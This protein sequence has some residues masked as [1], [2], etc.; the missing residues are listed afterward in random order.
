MTALMLLGA[1]FFSCKTFANKITDYF[2]L[3]NEAELLICDGHVKSAI[4]H[5]DRAFELQVSPFGKDVYNAWLCAYMLDDT[6]RFSQ[7][8]IILIRRGAFLHESTH[9]N[10]LNQVSGGPKVEKFSAI[11]R[12]LKAETPSE[13]DTVY[14][15]QL[16]NIF[17]RDQAVRHYFIDK[18]KNQYNIGGRDSLNVFD[19]LNTMHLKHLMQEKG[20]PTEDRVGFDNHFPGNPAIYDIPL[21]HD[22]SWTNRRTMDTL[23]YNNILKGNCSP[24][25]YAYYKWQS[26]GIFKDSI[27]KYQVNPYTNY[28]AYRSDIIDN[29]IYIAQLTF[30]DTTVI[31]AA[32]KSIHLET[33]KEMCVKIQYQFE[34]MYFKFWN[35]NVF[36]YS[37][38]LP[39]N[40]KENIEKH[41]ISK[42]AL[43]G[44]NII[45]KQRCKYG[46]RH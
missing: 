12:R 27:A 30:R 24:Q 32:R 16:V 25:D 6:A 31:D 7:F 8:S 14:R 23:L 36:M 26:L 45:S 1:I 2:Q 18:Y 33:V 21:M 15:Q 5:Y 28:G 35:P 41:A 19:S 37:D 34:H 42:S 17:D 46:L 22:R 10:I 4:E 38:G 13:V 40:V 20:F 29:H 39:D 44:F 11:W 3:V 9:E 43:D